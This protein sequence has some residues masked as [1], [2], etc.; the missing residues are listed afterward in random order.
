MLNVL[1]SFPVW[2]S[3]QID[4]VRAQSLS[5]SPPIY[6]S[7]GTSVAYLGAMVLDKLPVSGRPTIWVI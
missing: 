3:T 5:S 6:A 4:G 7:K 2:G 1:I